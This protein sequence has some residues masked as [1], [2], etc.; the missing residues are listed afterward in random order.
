MT[1]NSHSQTVTDIDGNIYPTVTIGTQTWMAQNLK[2]IHYRNGDSIPQVTNTY[3]WSILL[4]GAYCNY[5]NVNSNAATFGHLYTWYAVNDGRNIAPTGWHVATGAEWDTLFNFLGGE[6]V[7]GGKLKETGFGHWNSPNS[8][9]TNSSGFTALPGG[10]R[11]NNGVFGDL[12]NIGYFWNTDQLDMMSSNFHHVFWIVPN[13]VTKSGSKRYG[14]SVRCV[15][16][17]TPPPPPPPASPTIPTL[18][19]WGL[20]FLGFLLLIAGTF[21]ISRKKIMELR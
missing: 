1:F 20:I 5:N 6:A 21:Y 11:A 8:G 16:D 2:V 4:T 14:L 10:Y 3:D 12:G 15:K 19:Q 18:S 9:A 17:A 7:A 13:E